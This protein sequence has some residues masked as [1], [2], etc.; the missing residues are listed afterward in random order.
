MENIYTNKEKGIEMIVKYGS[1]NS[2]TVILKVDSKEIYRNHSY[3]A[4]K[5]IDQFIELFKLEHTGQWDEFGG[6]RN[7][8][9]EE[10]S[11]AKVK[12]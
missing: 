9:L 7:I 4:L 8:C 3:G 6:Y 10:M 1:F 2:T 11:N 12:N 5:E